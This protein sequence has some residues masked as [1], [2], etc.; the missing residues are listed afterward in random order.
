MNKKFEIIIKKN[1]YFNCII[2]I[3]VKFTYLIKI[4]LN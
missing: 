4:I 1:R 3:Y 2:L